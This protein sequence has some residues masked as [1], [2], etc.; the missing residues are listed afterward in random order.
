M[1]VFNV[2]IKSLFL[3]PLVGFDLAFR[4]KCG[5]NVNFKLT[6]GGRFLVNHGRV[7]ID[8]NALIVVK[9]GLLEIGSN[10]YIGVGSLI[11]AREKIIIGESALIA[12]YVSIRDQDH[13]L[14]SQPYHKA[15]FVTAPITIGNNVWIG[16]KAT[17]TKGVTIGDNAVIGANSVVTKDIP[18]NAVAAGVPAKVIRYIGENENSSSD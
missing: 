9:Y 14:T 1:K 18:A 13:A 3:I 2:F 10:A 12:E 17:I 15:G 4:I 6:D 7:D 5:S 8:R 16:A 11:C